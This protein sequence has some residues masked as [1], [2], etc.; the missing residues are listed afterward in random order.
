M[1][2]IAAAASLPRGLSGMK[3]SKIGSSFLQ[4]MPLVVVRSDPE[5]ERAIAALGIMIDDVAHQD[6]AGAVA[7]VADIV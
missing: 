7:G 4:N 3:L 5:I 1:P 6:Q 2:D